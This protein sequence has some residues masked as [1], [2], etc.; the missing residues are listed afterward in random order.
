M[1]FKVLH[2]RQVRCKRLSWN[3]LNINWEE[4]KIKSP[5]R[6][7]NLRIWGRSDN[8]KG[9]EGKTWKSPGCAGTA[10]FSNASTIA[11]KQNYCC[12]REPCGLYSITTE[13][14]NRQQSSLAWQ[15]ECLTFPVNKGAGRGR[16]GISI[17][18]FQ[19]PWDGNGQA[20]K[21]FGKPQWAERISCRFGKARY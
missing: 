2:F 15:R 16:A 1:S 11:N 17:P 8:P 12:T 7:T 4:I 6:P 3:I 14:S 18:T 10:D 13:G 20:G 19:P 21:A 5:W 9:K